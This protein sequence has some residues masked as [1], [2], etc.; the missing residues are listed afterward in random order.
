MRDSLLTRAGLLLG[1]LLMVAGIA[2]TPLV[3]AQAAADAAHDA[4]VEPAQLEVVVFE[5]GRPV[6][7]LIVR[8][9][10]VT[11][12]TENG[13]WRAT[14]DPSADRLTIFDNAQVLT[15]LPM[16][17]RPG[18]IV[19]VI[20]TLEGPERR[21]MVSIESS[22]GESQAEMGTTAP[23]GGS[24]AEQGSG[25]LTGRAVSTPRCEVGRGAR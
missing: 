11:G 21:A 1:L 6:N 12:R 2:I 3:Q 19:Q 8:F 7:D 24:D 10:Q 23:A 18:E 22:Y 13:I 9:D 15:A 14:V 20:V 25:M 4:V 16:T 17:L 5:G